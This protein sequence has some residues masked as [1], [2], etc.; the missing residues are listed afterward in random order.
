MP[1]KRE[2][3]HTDHTVEALHAAPPKEFTAAR[4]RLVQELKAAGRTD[5]ARAVAKL[6]R[7]PASVWAVNQ[8]ARRVPDEL[9]E[10]LELGAGLRSAE[11]RL[12]KGG[13]AGD[14]MADA[15]TAR[16]KVAALARR[17]DTFLE[18]AGQKPTAPLT[19]KIT[20]MLQ[21]ASVGDDETRAALRE[22]R[23]TGE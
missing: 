12:I 1:K 10:L 13:Q 4:A 7:P 11:K 8:L 20:Q 2:A 6:K 5:E 23:L 18:E 3:D 17:A 9:A 22:G 15:R 19:R 21:A 16:Q 14:F